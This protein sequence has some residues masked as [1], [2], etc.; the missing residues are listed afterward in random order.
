MKMA[1]EDKGERIS[2]GENKA[3]REPSTGKGRYDLISPFALKRI[4]IHYENGAK[5]YADRNWERGMPF[6][7]CIDSAKRH[8][9]QYVMGEKNEDHLSAAI[10]NLMAILHFEELGK[11]EL[12]DLPKYKGEDGCL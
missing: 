9:D 2:Y 5:K 6:S 11:E 8:L 10:W 1:L 7:R 4:A 12:N 3:V